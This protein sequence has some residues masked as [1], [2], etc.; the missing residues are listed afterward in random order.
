[1]KHSSIYGSALVIGSLGAIVTMIFHPS[2]QDLLGQPDEIARRNEMI[3]IATHSVALF[4]LPLLFFGFLGFSR[5]I[6]L[7]HPLVS[8]ALIAYAVA[9]IA[10]ICAVVIN[11]LVA[12]IITRQILTADEN[13]RQILRLIL[14]NNTLLNQ[15]FDKVFI[16]F[17]SLAIVSWSLCIKKAGRFAEIVAIF[18]YVLGL[19]SVLGILSGHLRMNVHGFGLVIFG[20]VIWTILLAVFLFHLGDSLTKDQTLPNSQ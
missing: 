18:G 6:G 4:S 13:T 11:G 19:I 12:P 2:G 10:A 3:T 9:L 1:M 8:A 15:A 20:Q 7:D 14:M 16:V 17:G 5:R